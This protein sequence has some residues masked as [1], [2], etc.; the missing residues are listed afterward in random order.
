MRGVRRDAGGRSGDALEKQEPHT[1]DVG[2][3]L[4]NH[5]K[6]LTHIQ[7]KSVAQGKPMPNIAMGFSWATDFEA[8]WGK[9][10]RRGQWNIST[11]G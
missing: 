2:K 7:H 5:I 8:Q 6:Y 4:R 11:A 10:M 9:V 3:N 1:K